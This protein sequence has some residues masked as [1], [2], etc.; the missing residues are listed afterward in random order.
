MASRAEQMTQEELFPKGTNIVGHPKGSNFVSTSKYN[1]TYMKNVGK[2]GRESQ[3]KS[4]RDQADAEMARLEKKPEKAAPKMEAKAAPKPRRSVASKPVAASSAAPA[5]DEAGN[6]LAKYK[7][8]RDIRTESTEG[9]GVK[10][11]AETEMKRVSLS[12]KPRSAASGEKAPVKTGKK[13]GRLRRAISA[14]GRGLRKVGRV[15]RRAAGG[16]RRPRKREA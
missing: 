15:I 1:D 16:K 7:T 4:M 12:A 6:R 5:K 2:A 13:R 11:L 8:K 10:P 14:T 9:A 3:Q